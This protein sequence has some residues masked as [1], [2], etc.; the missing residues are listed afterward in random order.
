MDRRLF[1][2]GLMG[3]GALGV[4]PLAAHAGMPGGGPRDAGP[5]VIV[6]QADLPQA[7][8]LA[9]SIA[10]SLDAAGLSSIQLSARSDRLGSYA[11]VA[12]ILER[13]G[14]AR[15]IGVMDDA[16]ALIFQQIAAARGAGWLMQTHHRI[17]GGE[18]RHCCS[19][20]GME[21]SLLWADAPQRVARLYAQAVG[22]GRRVPASAELAAAD[23]TALVGGGPASL[24][25]FAIN[26]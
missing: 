10:A 4:M 5:V 12:A 25:S 2:K 22:R 26:T 14:Q 11:G 23:A 1:L 3:S 13:A 18:L 17:G 21:S 19:V 15:L 7:S 6:V 20:A 24:V 16:S 8:V 9:R